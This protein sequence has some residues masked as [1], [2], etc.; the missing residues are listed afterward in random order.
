MFKIACKCLNYLCES[1]KEIIKSSPHCEYFA[2]MQ[3][4]Q[5]CR[6]TGA[7]VLSEEEQQRLYQERVTMLGG[8]RMRIRVQKGGH[9]T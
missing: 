8:L 1:I 4:E 9:T 7:T 5:T 6:I 2:E 3:E